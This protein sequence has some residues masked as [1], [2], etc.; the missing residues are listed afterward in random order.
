MSKEDM[1]GFE[2]PSYEEYCGDRDF[3]P[4]SDS[5]REQYDE[6]IDDAY[7]EIINNRETED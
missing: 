3:D 2:L 1:I 5:A 6:Y 4:S 7:Q